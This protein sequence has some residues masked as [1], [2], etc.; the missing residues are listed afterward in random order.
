M[1][2]INELLQFWWRRTFDMCDRVDQLPLFPYNRDKLIN[3]VVGI[4]YTLQGTNISPKN[5][6]LKMIFL[7]PKVGYVSSLEGTHYKDFLLKEDLALGWGRK[8][9]N[10]PAC[11]N[12][13][14]TW[15]KI[16]APLLLKGKK[17]G[18]MLPC[19]IG[20]HVYILFCYND[21]YMECNMSKHLSNK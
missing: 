8:V 13:G 14:V 18:M 19:L 9:P 16:G 11:S 1:T 2:V 12:A 17:A 7:F 15:R 4:Q 10:T 5:G 3:P 21:I 20:L 6:I